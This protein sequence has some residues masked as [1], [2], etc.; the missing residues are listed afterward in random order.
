MEIVYIIAKMG[1]VISVEPQG[2]R[3]N[4]INHV[5]KEQEKVSQF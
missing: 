4:D 3:E 5:F 2:M 1:N